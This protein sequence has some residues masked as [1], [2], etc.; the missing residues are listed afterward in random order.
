[1][2]VVRLVLAVG[3]LGTAR[4]APQEAPA[5]PL[6]LVRQALGRG[7]AAEAAAA[8]LRALPGEALAPAAEE[9]A[10]LADR[11]R[12]A[13][14]RAREARGRALGRDVAAQKQAVADELRSA[15][16]KL[17]R[18]YEKPQQ[19]EVDAL[20][21]KL[22]TIV[23]E[24]V[25]VEACVRGTEEPVAQWALCRELA[26]R[27]ARAA[28]AGPA[29]DAA[30]G[31]AT[32]EG[33]LEG[34]MSDSSLKAYLSLAEHQDFLDPEEA[35]CITATNRYRALLDLAPMRVDRKLV[36]A[37]RDHSESMVRLKFFSHTSPV[38]GKETFGARASAAGTSA[39]AE[40]IAQGQRTGEAA[41]DGWYHSPGH[42]RNIIGGGG[43]IGIG[44][45]QTMW[46]QMFG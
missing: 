43:R 44:R 22:R 18:T 3:L 2:R 25:P 33:L 8:A 30:L 35:A 26:A 10:R 16:R 32:R 15:I 1:M 5:D 45:F 29:P 19:P 31:E 6:A 42:H 12:E 21:A 20:V 38:K 46:T 36:L 28:E 37:A 13:A 27:A 41:F 24:S 4:A 39:S 40:N 9:I 7:A 34:W 14:L 11:T 17:V 23:Y